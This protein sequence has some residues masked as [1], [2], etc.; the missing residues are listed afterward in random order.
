M[1]WNEWI[2]KKVFIKLLD[3]T[4][5]SHSKV[6][7]YEDPFISVIDMFGLPVVVN[8]QNIM[9]ITEERK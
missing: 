8:V 9:R 6:L 1:D 2:G 7:V 5:F 4:I 3:G